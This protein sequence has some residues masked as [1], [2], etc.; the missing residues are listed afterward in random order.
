MTK[1]ILFYL[2]IVVAIVAFVASVMGIPI[3]GFNQTGF[4]GSSPFER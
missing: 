4:Q 1:W 2:L 3:P